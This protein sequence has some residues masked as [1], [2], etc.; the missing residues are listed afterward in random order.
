MFVVPGTRLN[1][2]TVNGIGSAHPPRA[3]PV[4]S[5]RELVRAKNK[6]TELIEI[7]QV[8]GLEVESSLAHWPDETNA[9]GAKVAL[10]LPARAGVRKQ[11]GF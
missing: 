5:R 9:P 1:M 3:K 11:R 10:K 2:A 6:A 7:R 4:R 8:K